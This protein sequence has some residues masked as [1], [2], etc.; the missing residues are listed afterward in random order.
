MASKR[1]TIIFNP[2]SG[3][4]GRRA[5]DAQL[6]ARLLKERGI[7]TNTCATRGPND[8]TRIAREVVSEGVDIIVSYGGDGTLNEVIQAM[9]NTQTQLAV[10]AGGTANVVAVDLEMPKDINE[11]ADVIAAGRQKRISLG[12]ARAGGGEWEGES[13]EASSSTPPLP[14]SPTPSSAHSLTQQSGR[15]FFMFAGIGLDA[16]IARSVNHRLK[17]R[18]GEMAYWLAGFRHLFTWEPENFT[19]DID[20]HKYDAVFAL[21]GKGKGYG[22]GFHVTPNA[23]LEDPWFEVYIV[24]R[25]STNFAYLADLA[26]CFR[27]ARPREGVKLV[28]GRHIEANSTENPWVEVDGEVI[29]RLPMIFDVAPDA[30]SII[31]P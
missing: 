29:G 5:E 27:G 25:R 31:V 15:Y 9:A 6:M 23:R 14:H 2:A 20:G 3:Q 10:W 30:L 21:V 19:L 18:A 12:V 8:A 7:E 4:S 13:T 1:A 17:R 11:L 24:P 26:R 28:R 16:S 22:G